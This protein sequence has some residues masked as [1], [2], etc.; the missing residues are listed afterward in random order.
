MKALR[1]IKQK[2]KGKSA[3][4]YRYRERAY[5]GLIT[6]IEGSGWLGCSAGL[7]LVDMLKVSAARNNRIV[8]NY[9][10]NHLDDLQRA[11]LFRLLSAPEHLYDLFW[12][13][14]L[15]SGMDSSDIS[16]QT[17]GDFDVL[18]LRDGSCCYT[19]TIVRRVRKVDERYVTLT[20]TN[21]SFPIQKMRRCVLA[22]WAGEV[23]LQ[24]LAHLHKLGLS[25]MQIKQM[26]LSA[27]T[28]NSPIIGTAELSVRLKPLLK[29]GRNPKRH[30]DTNQQKWSHLSGNASRRYH[31]I[32]P[33]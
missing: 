25:D 11:K 14:L 27:E 4:A 3:S 23:L 29:T 21:D 16:G 30:F 9:R 32:T 18:T 12:V 15:Y 19:I 20:A 8:Q 33:T 26:R 1:S 31:N 7:H 2:L 5:K 13:S 6:A 10:L 28:P 22:P 24:W 17:F